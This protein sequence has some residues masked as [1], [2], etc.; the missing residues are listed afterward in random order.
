MMLDQVTN[1]RQRGANPGVVRNATVLQG[2]I[3]IGA[4]QNPLAADVHVSDGLPGMETRFHLENLGMSRNGVSQTGFFRSWSDP[5]LGVLWIAPAGKSPG[6]T[7]SASGVWSSGGTMTL[8]SKQLYSKVGHWHSPSVSNESILRAPMTF[9]FQF[10]M[11][12][13]GGLRHPRTTVKTFVLAMFRDELLQLVHVLLLL[14][15]QTLPEGL[16]LFVVFSV[17]N[18]LIIPPEG[19]E[20]FAQFVDH[21]VIMI[22]GAFGFTNLLH[23]SFSYQAHNGPF[24][25]VVV[26][27]GIACGTQQSA[28]N[29]T[30]CSNYIS[31]DHEQSV[32]L[33]IFA[34]RNPHVCS[35]FFRLPPRTSR[36]P[37]ATL[38]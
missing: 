13:E 21:I 9:S 36:C 15:L 4:H 10:A 20:P 35:A 34:A 16:Q 28:V 33:P 11:R 5:T 25:V 31:G 7:T 3:E 24:M 6:Q 32:S 1:G 12:Q 8:F 29:E 30:D 17:G 22:R 2:H 38:G 27:V 37:A 19:V 14:L 18:V 26:L 23:L